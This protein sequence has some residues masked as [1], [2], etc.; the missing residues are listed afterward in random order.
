MKTYVG[1]FIIIFCLVSINSAQ[2]GFFDKEKSNVSVKP[3][4]SKIIP[5]SEL[6]FADIGAATK[7]GKAIIN[8]NELELIAGGADIWGKNDEFNF[9]YKKLVGDFD[10]SVQIAGLT[11]PHQYTKAGIMARV[12][13]TDNSE[14]VYY[15][16][17]PDN[18]ARNKNNG[19]CEFQY[20]L[21]KGGDMKAIYPNPE[22]AGNKFDVNFPN[23]WIRLK[24]IGDIF[25][26]YTGRD[27]KTWNLYSTYTQK[28]P[29]ELLVGLAV[30]S[31]NSE[32]FTTAVFSNLVLKK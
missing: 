10:I 31:H 20:R 24:R 19:G 21:E 22:T 3:E 30:T 25:E 16:V 18:S 7:P 12:D 23:T 8:K 29:N 4:K 11:K 28:L 32:E 17:F 2:A 1:L 26:S 5:F 27:N 9:G 13:L 14:H 15:Q 6:K